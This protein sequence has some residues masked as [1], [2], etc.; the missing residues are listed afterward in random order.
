MSRPSAWVFCLLIVVFAGLALPR[1]GLAQAL[2]LALAEELIN[3]VAA[4]GTDDEIESL[5]VLQHFYSVRGERPLWVLDG[6]AGPRAARLSELLTAAD[7]DGLDPL[8]YRA[9]QIAGLLGAS[10]PPDLARL[11]VLLSLGLV[12]YASDLGQGRTTPHIADPELFVFRQEVDKA[13]VLDAAARATDLDGFIAG[14]RPQTD[15]YLRQKVALA[16]YRALAL[17]GGWRPIPEGDT[18]KPGMTDP[19]VGL[20]RGRLRLVGD[21]KAVDDEAERGGNPNFFDDALAAAVYMLASLSIAIFCGYLLRIEPVE[22]SVR[23]VV[24]RLR[25]LLGTLA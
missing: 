13:A 21:L 5:S 12:R 16:E 3:G 11:E 25:R 10:T 4:A 23:I 8:D 24:R 18:L 6:E 15:R 19:R 20:L 1:C 17:Q 22:A 9:G 7:L 2:P 14:Y